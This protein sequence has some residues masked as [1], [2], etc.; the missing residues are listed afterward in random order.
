ME[1]FE[2]TFNFF[3]NG[4]WGYVIYDGDTLVG[5]VSR[6]DSYDEAYGDAVANGYKWAGED[7]EQTMREDADMYAL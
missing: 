6:F 1:T 7:T 3:T 4:K 5:S 2:I